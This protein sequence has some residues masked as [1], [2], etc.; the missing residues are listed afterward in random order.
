[1]GRIHPRVEYGGG[2]VAVA[3]GFND[4]VEKEAEV[5]GV[6]GAEKEIGDGK[7]EQEGKKLGGHF[8]PRAPFSER[9]QGFLGK[10]AE[11]PVHGDRSEKE[12]EDEGKTGEGGRQKQGLEEASVS[13]LSPG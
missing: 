12:E 4:V 13:H 6:Q 3:N 2:I 1:M 8:D 5:G 10:Q 7:K 11:E 9:V